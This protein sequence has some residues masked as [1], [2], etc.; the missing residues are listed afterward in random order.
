[1]PKKLHRPPLRVVCAPWS[2]RSSW[3]VARGS[4][5]LSWD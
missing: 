2:T 1:M 4:R 3:I 5:S